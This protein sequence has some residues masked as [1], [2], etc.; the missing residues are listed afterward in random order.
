MMQLLSSETEKKKE[1]E[2]EEE[3]EEGEEG[4]SSVWTM[5]NIFNEKKW[6]Q[7]NVNNILPLA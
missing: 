5:M 6:G 4:D 3:E 1:G 7:D 2:E